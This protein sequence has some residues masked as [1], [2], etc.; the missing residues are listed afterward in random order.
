MC[1][2]LASTQVCELLASTLSSVRT[3]ASTFGTFESYDSAV[4]RFLDFAHV[5]IFGN[6]ISRSIDVN[7][8]GKYTRCTM[9]IDINFVGKY[10]RCT[11]RSRIFLSEV[12]IHLKNLESLFIDAKLVRQGATLGVSLAFAF[13]SH[14]RGG[15]PCEIKLKPSTYFHSCV[16]E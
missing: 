8:V 16:N 6:V 14:G 10:T 2:T 9:R 3:L 7:F 1:E 15:L 13:L 12:L 11:M 4:D 5:A